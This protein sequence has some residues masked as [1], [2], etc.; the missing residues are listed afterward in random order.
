MILSPFLHFLAYFGIA[1]THS[2]LFPYFVSYTV[3]Y[4]LDSTLYFAGLN[5]IFLIICAPLWLYSIFNSR[6]IMGVDTRY[7][8]NMHYLFCIV[9]LITYPFT[10]KKSQSFYLIHLFILNIVLWGL[11][12]SLSYVSYGTIM[13]YS[14][15]I[16]DFTI[17]VCGLIVS[18]LKIGSC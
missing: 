3:F 10:Q 5:C 2:L 13:P 8:Y 7:I 11:I 9:Y 6:M 4:G 17:P 14:M 1:I 12:W 15:D 16:M 18:M